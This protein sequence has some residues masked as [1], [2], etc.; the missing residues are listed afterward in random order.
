[1]AEGNQFG[2]LEY[3]GFEVLFVLSSGSRQAVVG[4]SWVGR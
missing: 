3:Y 2:D 4:A 1:M